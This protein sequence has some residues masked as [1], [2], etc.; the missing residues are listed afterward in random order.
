MIIE[1]ELQKVSDETMRFMRGKY[2]LDEVGDGKDKLEL[3][4]DGETLITIRIHEDRYDFYID[5]KCIPVTD[6][7]TLENVKQIIMLK[8]KP[9]RKPFSKE[10]AVYSDCGYR[11]DLCVHY[12]GGTIGA[13]LRSDLKERLNRVYGKAD[14]WGD[15]MPFCDS[16]TSDGCMV[17][18]PNAPCEKKKCMASKSVDKC[19]N[20]AQYPCY[21]ESTHRNRK[22]HSMCISADD[23]TRVILCYAPGQYGN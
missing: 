9:N 7:E 4:E 20:C 11:C 14:Y 19:T 21:N 23:V 18:L 1:T 15:N 6:L 13:E 2:V 5:D 8:K 16:C 22:I 10:Q 12:T 17:S 3:R